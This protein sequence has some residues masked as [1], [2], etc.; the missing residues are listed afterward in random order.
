MRV[1]IRQSLEW[2][3]NGS[4]LTWRS[5]VLFCVEAVTAALPAASYEGSV[6]SEHFLYLLFPHL[7]LNF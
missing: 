2:P 3:S 1:P 4:V 7:D 5:H 6:F